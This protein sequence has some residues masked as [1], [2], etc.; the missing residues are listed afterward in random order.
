MRE[1]SYLDMDKVR[2]KVERKKPP[3]S[4]GG[5]GFWKTAATSW[6]S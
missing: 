5:R 2:F 6:N 4:G 3:E 1:L